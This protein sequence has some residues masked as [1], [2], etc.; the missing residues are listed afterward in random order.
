[1]PSHVI[2]RFD[3]EPKERR[4]DVTFV[5]G[6]RYAYFEVPPETYEA[7]RLSFAKGE[8]FN[9]HIRDHFRFEARGQ[10]A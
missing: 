5:S 7:M 9:A 8:F 6:R 10:D 1:M 4:L 2:R 3:Y